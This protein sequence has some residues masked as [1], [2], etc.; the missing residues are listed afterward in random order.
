MR[1]S[2]QMATA[3]WHLGSDREIEHLEDLSRHSVDLSNQFS[4]PRAR[5]RGGTFAARPGE[6]AACHPSCLPRAGSV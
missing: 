6:E 2:S 3:P 4:W 5:R 1:P